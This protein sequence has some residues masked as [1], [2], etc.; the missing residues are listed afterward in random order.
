MHS[1]LFILCGGSSI[2]CDSF[3]PRHMD[4]RRFPLPNHTIYTVWKCRSV[5]ALYCHDHDKQVNA[6][7]NYYNLLEVKSR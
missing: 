7:V 6:W 4:A 5:I 1:R 2:Q 3:L